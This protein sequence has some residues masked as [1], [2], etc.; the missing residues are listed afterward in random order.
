[1]REWAYV[2]ARADQLTVLSSSAEPVKKGTSRCGPGNTSLTVKSKDGPNKRQSSKESVCR[3][4]KYAREPIP[5][6]R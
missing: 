5:F 4:G 1:M 2:M 6:L 3:I